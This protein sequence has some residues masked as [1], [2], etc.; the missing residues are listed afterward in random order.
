MQEYLFKH[1]LREKMDTLGFYTLIIFLCCGWFLLLW[2]LRLQALLAGLGLA[3]LCLLLRHKTRAHRL[4]MKEKK[5]RQRIGGEMQLQQLL[6][7]PA[8][9]AQFEMALLLSITENITLERITGQ[10]VLCKKDET[11]LLLSFLQ[12]PFSD[13]LTA[14]DVLQLQQHAQQEKAGEI[15]LCL[16]ASLS[17]AAQKQAEEGIPL[18]ILPREKLIALLGAAAPAT[19]RQLVQLG[20]QRKHPSSLRQGLRIIFQPEKARRYA[21]YS[22]MLLFLYTV[23]GLFYYAVP[24]LICTLLA[25][26]S[27]CRKKG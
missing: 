3:V 2:G 6:L 22:V 5:L 17:E 4:M 26:A 13:S 12:L 19:D 7:K 10:G 14:R 8:R 21:L 18:R 11:L 9:Q 24:G 15:W 25:T 23:T 16:P 20:R 27:H 1:P